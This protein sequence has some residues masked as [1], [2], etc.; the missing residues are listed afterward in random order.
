MGILKA[1][2]DIIGLFQ[3][4]TVIDWSLLFQPVLST[5]AV[6]L[7]LVSLQLLLIGMVADGLVRRIGQR[8][9]PLLPSHATR[10]LEKKDST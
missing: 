1:I 8:A 4:A 6:L 5:S 7:L 2:F 10:H 9:G 3:R